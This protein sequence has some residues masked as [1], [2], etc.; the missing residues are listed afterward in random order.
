MWVFILIPLVF[1]LYFRR[2]LNTF[3]TIGGILH[4]AMFLITI[5]T[6]AV[7]AQRS[8]TDFV[9][10]TLLTGVSDWTDPGVSFG[11]GLLTV[12][13]PVAGKVVV[14][15]SLITETLTSL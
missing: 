9:F 3:E 5:I 13:Y 15:S 6:L 4:I 12:V 2:L 7:L 10:K 8:T 1:N 14:Q 11:I